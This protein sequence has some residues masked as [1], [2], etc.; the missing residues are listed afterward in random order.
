VEVGVLGKLVQSWV[1]WFLI[2]KR[3]GSPTEGVVGWAISEKAKLC[4]RD[5]AFF[6]EIARHQRSIF[7]KQHDGRTFLKSLQL[8]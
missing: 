5:K 6:L 1:R 7:S 8:W 2:E 4:I 3:A